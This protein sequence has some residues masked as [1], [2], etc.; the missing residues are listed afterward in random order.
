MVQEWVDQES[1]P[2]W[3]GVF[4]D[5]PAFVQRLRDQMSPE[6]VQPGRVPSHHFWLVTHDQRVIGISSLRHWLMPHLE[7]EGGHI[8][9]RIRPSERRK[10]YGT[11]LL[12]LTLEKAIGIGLTRV[13]V[14][15]DEDNIGSRRIIEKNGGQLAGKGISEM[16]G[17]PVLRYWIDLTRGAETRAEIPQ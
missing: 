14:T 11:R 2:V 7:K 12:A 15:C 3:E 4:D 17:K 1:G 10:G 9:Y 8:G 5:F 6:T 16:T 13:L